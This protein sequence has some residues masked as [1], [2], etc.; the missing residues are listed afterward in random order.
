MLLC[1][2]VMVHE[3]TGIAFIKHVEVM[4]PYVLGIGVL[5]ISR[6]PFRSFKEFRTQS[7][8]YLFFGSILL[9]FI[10]LAV[11]GPG[12]TIL[13]CLLL[14]YVLSGLVRKIISMCSTM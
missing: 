14:F 11:G 8:H 6:I 12:G 4:G 13:W 10:V 3:E 5:M 9:G 7:G 1:T 2:A